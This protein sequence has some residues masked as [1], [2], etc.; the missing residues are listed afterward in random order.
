MYLNSTLLIVTFKIIK[1]ICCIDN[2]SGGTILQ[3]QSNVND[4]NEDSKWLE[5]AMLIAISSS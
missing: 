3:I 1:N 2:L 4:Y 5:Q